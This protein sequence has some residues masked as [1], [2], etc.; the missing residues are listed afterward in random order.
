MA[1]TTYRELADAVFNK[2]KDVD[3]ASINEEIAYQIV[4]GYMRPAIVSYQSAK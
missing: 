3:F 1:N 2:I 4:I